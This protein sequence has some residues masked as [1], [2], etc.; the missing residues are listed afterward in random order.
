MSRAHPITVQRK[1]GATGIPL[2]ATLRKWALV[3]LENTEG[4]LTIRI[5]DEAESAALNARFRNRPQPTNVLS[6]GYAAAA[7]DMPALGDL[8]ICAPIVAREAA[9][10]GK[11]PRSHWA[12]MVVHG[13]LHLRGYDHERKADAAVMETL[14]RKILASLGFSNPYCD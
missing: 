10:Q 13:V 7:L 8:V 6:F 11:T 12:H 4:E 14:E 5:V 9:A 2:P 1:V 3:A